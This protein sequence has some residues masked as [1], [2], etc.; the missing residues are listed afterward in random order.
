MVKPFCVTWGLVF[1]S[2]FV[3]ICFFLLPA[4]KIGSNVSSQ[5]SL[6]LVVKTYLG[7]TSYTEQ[8]SLLNYFIAVMHQGDCNG[9]GKKKKISFTPVPV[10]DRYFIK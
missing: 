3:S 9:S 6:L 5:Q 10:P 7:G 8:G 2:S 4:E 1:P